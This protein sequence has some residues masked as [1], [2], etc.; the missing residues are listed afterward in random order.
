MERALRIDSDLYLSGAVSFYQTEVDDHLVTI[1]GETHL[2]GY[3]ECSSKPSMSVAEFIFTFTS[4]FP[5]TKI[6]L[7]YL[8]G[9]KEWSPLLG[10]KNMADT[11]KLLSE[12]NLKNKMI[13]FD[14]RSL[15]LRPR[16]QEVLYH[17][18]HLL[19][20]LDEKTITGV[21]VWAIPVGIVP[22]L[23]ENVKT[24]GN[25]SQAKYLQTFL[26]DLNQHAY[27][28]AESIQKRWNTDPKDKKSIILSIK[29]LWAKVSDFAIV[30]EIFKQADQGNVIVLCGEKHAENL[31]S[32]FPKL[33]FQIISKNPKECVNVRGSIKKL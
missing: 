31:R 28:I 11:Y 32:I 21:F 13:G 7:E 27:S 15:F 1:I 5:N 8:P 10:S 17:Q 3:Q 30:Y 26:D 12:G 2:L 24:I 9:L 29:Y 33:L 4:H 6:L 22:K 19:E 20:D 18:S 23:E 16:D 25:K 14:L